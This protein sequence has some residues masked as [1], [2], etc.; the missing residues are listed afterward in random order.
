MA[1]GMAVRHSERVVTVHGSYHPD[2]GVEALRWSACEAELLQALH[3]ARPINRA[4]STPLRIHIATSVC[5]PIEVDFA[6]TWD[7]LRPSLAEVMLARGYWVS[8]HA[9][10][11]ALFPDL[12]ATPLAAKMAVH[13]ERETGFK[14]YRLYTI[15]LETS[16]GRRL[17]VKRQYNG[18]RRLRPF[19]AVRFRR[20]GSRG[21]AGWLL[22]D[23]ERFPDPAALL[24]ERLGCEVT[25]LPDI[26]D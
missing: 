22:F 14:P 16:F 4:P 17:F 25:I 18:P 9:E 26:E 12:F 15:G 7:E 21:P 5:L 23:P 20:A 8:S 2:E 10:M 19:V 13:H 24:R 1:R 6:R 11:A 3:R